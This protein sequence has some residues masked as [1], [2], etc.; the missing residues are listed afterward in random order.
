MK[1]AF[2]LTLYANAKQSN[3]FIK[4]LLQYEDAYVFIHIDAKNKRLEKELYRHERVII[5][6]QNYYI[7]WGDF[8]QIEANLALINFANKY[9]EF[10]Y[11]SVHSGNDLLVQPLEKL[12]SFLEKDKAYAY[13]DCDRLPN[14][15]FQYGGGLGRI[16]MK[17]PKCFRK[18]YR[19]HSV[20]RYLR[21][22][23]GRLYGIK[24]L[25][26][27]KLP[28]NMT[29]YGRSDWFTLSEKCVKNIILYLKLNP[30]YYDIYRNSLI[31][32]ELFFN[33]MAF[34]T[35]EDEDIIKQHNNLRYIDFV[36]VDKN[37]PGSPKLLKEEDYEKIKAS[38]AFFARKVD[39]NNKESNKLIK[40][41]IGE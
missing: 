2:L 14:E 25:K 16:A 22:I 20:M 13:L 5:I 31:G 24:I 12:S 3:I 11:Y 34:L 38:G 29:F 9:S 19:Q 18:K 35:K 36:N 32:S 7:E 21:A 23:Y 26:G 39:C 30:N 1:I 15:K 10:K 4:Q 40:K 33:S 6:P 27:K 37:T 28:E 17:W 8:S 41:Y